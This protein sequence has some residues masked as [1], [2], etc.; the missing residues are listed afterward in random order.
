[1]AIERCSLYARL[2]RSSAVQ[3]DRCIGIWVTRSACFAKQVGGVYPGAVTIGF[4]IA[5]TPF[6][7]EGTCSPTFHGAANILSFSIWRR[8]PPDRTKAAVTMGKGS[9]EFS[10]S[11]LTCQRSRLKTSTTLEQDR[12]LSRYSPVDST[13]F[14]PPALRQLK[15]PRPAGLLRVRRCVPAASA[16]RSLRC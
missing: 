1:M 6:D 5:P 2:N 8:A 3:T 4:P 13:A 12:L 9:L 16:K 14:A 10:G 7:K 11:W 15:A